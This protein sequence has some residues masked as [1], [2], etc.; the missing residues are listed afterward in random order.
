MRLGRGPVPSVLR[1]IAPAVMI[2]AALVCGHA[3]ADGRRSGFDDMSPGTQAMQ[4]DDTANPGMLFV[5]EG[6]AAWQAPAGPAGRSCAS[7]HGPGERMRG[8]AVGYPAFDEAIATPVDLQGRIALCRTRHQGAEP[9]LR[10]GK[11]LLA[12]EAY[13]AHQSRSLPLRPVDDPRL[14]SARDEGA[15]LWRRRQ[16]QLDL[17][18]AA[19][20]DDNAGRKLGAS[21]IPQGHPTGYPVYRLEWQ[22]MGSLQRRLRNCMI[23]VRAEPYPYGDTA[24]VALELYLRD[25]AAGM[26]VETPAV[27]P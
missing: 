19:C 16:G 3:A 17:S 15:A 12:L 21:L 4:R 8:V 26:I 23:G 5:A 20:H 25:R 18:C 2:L 10:E 22:A 9:L 1:A 14:I 11:A 6:E 13:V 27:R 24:F 7:C